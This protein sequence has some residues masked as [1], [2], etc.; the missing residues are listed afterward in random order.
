MPLPELHLEGKRSRAH[1]LYEC[2][3]EAIFDGDLGPGERLV[4]DIIAAV[5]KTSRTPVREALRKLEVEGLVQDA[6]RGMVVSAP[7]SGELADLCAVREVLEG[8]A[9]RLAAVSRSDTEAEILRRVFDEVRLATERGDVDRLVEAN[10]DFHDTIWQ[11]TRNR[12]L[13]QQLATLRGF[14]ERLQPTTLRNQ[15]RRSEALEEH[16]RILTAIVERD[17]GKAE[18]YARQH[19][20]NG[21]AARITQQRS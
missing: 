2:L 8:M 5:A 20:R 12:Y 13:G 16:Q 6:G 10:R 21:E 11:A 3:R 17:P 19:F 15:R 7:T 4:E 14:I 1:E 18:E 9:A